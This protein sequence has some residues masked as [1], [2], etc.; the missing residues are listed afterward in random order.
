MRLEKCPKCGSHLNFSMDYCGGNPVIIYTC[1]DC[2]FTTFGEAYISDNKT[3]ATVG[4]SITTNST[5]SVYEPTG[6]V[7]KNNGRTTFT[8]G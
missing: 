7:K 6:V 2:N 1:S 3:T 4:S 5:N 8:V